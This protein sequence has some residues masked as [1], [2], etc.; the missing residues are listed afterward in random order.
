MD[1]RENLRAAYRRASAEDIRAGRDWYPAAARAVVAIAA[2][3]GIGAGPVAYAV[4][5][6][7]PRNPWRW[8]VADAANLAAWARDGLPGDGPRVTTFGL[9]RSIAIDALTGTPNGWCSAA[10]KVRSFVANILGDTDAVTVDTWA[11]RA[12][13]AGA[14][15]AVRGPRDYAEIAQAYRDV[16]AEVGETPRDLQAILWTLTIREAGK[17]V[18]GH[19]ARCKTGTPDYVR[20]LFA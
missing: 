17:D 8:N 18:R 13:T 12:A 10:P 4:A 3:T 16:A 19:A 14:R 6:L 15:N 20:A 9:N 1:F 7:S 2:E 11:V 5:A